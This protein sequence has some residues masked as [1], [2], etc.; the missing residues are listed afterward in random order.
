LSHLDR[1]RIGRYTCPSGI[2]FDFQFDELGREGGKKSAVHELPQQDAAIV[3]DLGGTAVKF[4]LKIYFSGPDYDTVA[5]S[6]FACLAEKGP[7]LLSHPRWGDVSVLATTY[8]QSEQFVDGLGEAIF[9]VSFVY[10]PGTAAVASSAATAPAVASSSQAARVRAQAAMAKDFGS[11]KL[12]DLME[13]KD[14]IRKTLRE[15]KRT[16]LKLT[17]SVKEISQRINAEIIAIDSDLDALLAFPQDFA[18]ALGSVISAAASAPFKIADSLAAYSDLASSIG[19]VP[20]TAAQAAVAILT[21]ALISSSATEAS[22]SGGFASR[23]EAIAA[24]DSLVALADFARAQIENAEASGGI[25]ADPEAMEAQA[26]AAAA[27]AAYLLETS[28]SLR[29]ERRKIIDGAASPVE[30]A[31]RFYRDIGRTDELCAQN[32]FSGDFLLIVP[33]GTEVRYYAE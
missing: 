17:G 21:Q 25:T 33:A 32:E 11:P 5:D 20:A 12:R 3:Q 30:L 6:F 1:L 4:P 7:G 18:D 8:S 26:A 16:M 29:V 9:D 19:T 10:A 23:A 22:T 24:H 31:F 14:Q 2:T 28:F 27:A 13:T 15:T